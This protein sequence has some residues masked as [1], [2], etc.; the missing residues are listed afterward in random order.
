MFSYND[1]LGPE[2]LSIEHKEFS[3]YKTGVQFD[4]SQAETYCETNKFEFNDIVLKTIP[5]YIDY[6]PKYVC[7]FLNSSITDG[8]LYVGVDD[9]GF[10][11]GIPLRSGET[12]NTD[13]IH[14][15]VKE[16]IDK[17]VRIKKQVEDISLEKENVITIPFT[18]ECI[19]IETEHK[20]ELHPEYLHYLEQKKRYMELV[21]THQ[22]SYK[23]WLDTFEFATMKLVDIVNIPKN[24]ERLIEYM[25]QAH[26]YN[27]IALN[28][29]RDPTYQLPSLEGQGL[30]RELKLDPN[31][32]F[33]WVTRFKD[34]LNILYKKEKPVFHASFK[35]R[36]T[37]FTL[38]IGI[39]DMIP[40]WADQISVYLL[41]IKFQLPVTQMTH[42][43]EKI[44]YEF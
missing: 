5:K 13:W 26:D 3:L 16:R 4:L 34:E 42:E 28:I 11:K 10:I 17:F 6:I 1:C 43:S 19:E 31:S 41:K 25:E 36:H 39:S 2:T 12:I 38:L 14:S 44:N 35:Q 22:Q 30:V 33:H 23:K 21:V 27:H 37:P 8:T 9:D 20:S 29:I 18:V 24:R 7:G 40:Y 15:L 32:V